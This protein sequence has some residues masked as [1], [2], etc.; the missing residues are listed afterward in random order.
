MH[1]EPFQISVSDVEI[2]DLRRRLRETRWASMTPSEPWQQGT[3]PTW[4][5]EWVTYWAESFDWRAAERGLNQQPQFMADVNGQRVHFVH[6]RGVGP[7]PYP[8]V[9]THGWPGS[10]FEFHA[11]ADLLCDPAAFGG[12]PSDA[13]DVIIP[14]LPGFG[15]SPAPA[16]PALR[17][18]K[19]PICGHR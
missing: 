3:E 5:R 17:R 11:L 1:I 14:S 15:F 4:L 8:V 6:R 13:F 18:F 10:F 2:D 9:I 19:W 16:P 7:R 12:D